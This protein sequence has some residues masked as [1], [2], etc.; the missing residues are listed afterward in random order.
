M[1][2]TIKNIGDLDT[3]LSK[4]EIEKLGKAHAAVVIESDQFDV[5]KTY[6]ALK[7]YELYL[8]TMIDELKSETVK[9]ITESGQKDFEFGT[10]KV[11]ITKRRKFDFSN[12]AYWNELAKQDKTVSD[13]KKSHEAILKKMKEGEIKEIVNETTGEVQ[14]VHGPSVVI[15]ENLMVKIA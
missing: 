15:S 11:T 2:S 6:S 12:D 4:E 10:S 14:M 5:I 13:Q 7:R 9:K 1:S 3:T 8:K